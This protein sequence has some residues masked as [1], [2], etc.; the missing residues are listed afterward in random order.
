MATK[1]TEHHLDILDK[2]CAHNYSPLKVV[3]TEASGVWVTDI[4]GKR[5]LDM[6]SAYSGLNFGHQNPRILNAARKQLERLTLVSR[7]FCTEELGLM[8][9]ELAELCGME[10]VLPMNSGAEA[11]ESAIKLARRWG[12]EKK[13][14][15]DGKAEI[16]C[17]G[18]NF[19]GRTTTIISFSDS[20]ESRRGFGPFTPGFTLV[21][22]GDSAAL[23]KAITPN[24]VAVLIEPIQG[25]A[26]IIIPPDGFLRAVR[27]ICSRNNVLMIA[28]EIQSGFCRSGKLFACDWES[29]VPDLYII[30]K[31]L[32]GGI[33][34]I[35][36]VISFRR[37]M[38][39]FTP[40]SHGSTFSGNPLACAIA[41]E[42]MS[43]I[44][45]EKPEEKAAELGLYFEKRLRGMKNSKFEEIRARGLWVGVD[46]PKSAGKAKGFCEKL[47]ALG[48][49]CK[50][51]RD[52]SIRFAPPLTISRE[53]LDFG[54]EKIE[55]AFTD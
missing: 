48:V 50:D 44:R 37:F 12:Y 8:C 23:E 34:P 29:V 51:T 16:V 43:L 5:Y 2:Y 13:N 31:S 18:G 22:F 15:P 20:E 38:E 40:G 36:A 42:V 53:E 19:H 11:I 49:L 45:E 33:M 52:Y 35:S 4:D 47:Q 54:I 25:E 30:G 1:E 7:A 28:D 17:F 55:R 14:V 3:I 6:H 24:T 10:M 32:G 46:L 21:P 26:G 27:E 41:R 9:K 39:V